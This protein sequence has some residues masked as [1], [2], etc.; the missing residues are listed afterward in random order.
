MGNYLEAIK[1]YEK[2]AEIDALYF[3][4]F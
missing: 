2:A 3:D 1:Y 4:A